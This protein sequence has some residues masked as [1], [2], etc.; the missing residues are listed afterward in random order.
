MIEPCF[1][2]IPQD[3]YA[4]TYHVFK[5]GVFIFQHQGTAGDIADALLNRAYA[6]KGDLFEVCARSGFVE[7]TTTVGD[8]SLLSDARVDAFLKHRNN[9]MGII[10]A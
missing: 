7:V 4:H 9:R 8:A 3:R 6:E 5:D 1:K 10:T 2:I